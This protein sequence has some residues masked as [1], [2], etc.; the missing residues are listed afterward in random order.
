M[1]MREDS[2]LDSPVS[3][4][5]FQR[6]IPLRASKI[7]IGPFRATQIWNEIIDHLKIHVEVKRRRY[8]MKTYDNTFSGAHAVD[9]VMTYLL[10]EK[11][12]FSTDL[13][14]DKAV[15]LCQSLMDRQVFCSISNRTSEIKKTFDD[16]HNKLYRFVGLDLPENHENSNSTIIETSS[17]DE[18]HDYSIMEDCRG[19]QS[20]RLNPE[21]DQEGNLDDSVICNPIAVNKKGQVLQ[22]IISLHQSFTRRRSRSSLKSDTSIMS[23]NS[24]RDSTLTPEVM[25]SLWREVALC[26]LLTTVEIPFLEGLLSDQKSSKKTVK[27][28]MIT[29]SVSKHYNS[30]GINN[31][32][33]PFMRTA[34]NCIECLPKGLLVLE[35]DFVRGQN[36]AA[37]IQAFHVLSG[38][39]KSQA[40]SLMPENFIEVHLAIL[41]FIIQQ[42]HEMAI[43]A[44]QL[45]L[46]IL[47]WHIRE[48]LRRLLKFMTACAEMTDFSVDSKVN[49]ETLALDT[50][51]DCIIQHKVLAHKLAR[52]LVLFLMKNLKRIFTVPKEIKDRVVTRMNDLKTGEVSPVRDNAYCS[53]VT[54][55]EYQKQATECTNTALVSMMNG[56]LDNTNFTLKE[57]KQRLRQFQKCHPELYAKHF[58]GML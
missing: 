37:K 13:S 36:P 19:N 22:E 44:L 14:R 8:K 42:K 15:K 5:S 26:Q 9:V 21:V 30:V 58:I 47:P 57:K 39:Y 28:N 35:K 52:V 7:N 17:S 45:D 33:D 43:E 38:H 56:I 20:I 54:T 27:Q 34:L 53:Q 31:I 48:E 41:N 3:Y 32:T 24:C 46:I 4:N 49:N 1:A 29:N 10:S 6:S 2:L 11:N 25:E 23:R 12:T 40:N 55:D 50:F 16:S 18:E 51:T